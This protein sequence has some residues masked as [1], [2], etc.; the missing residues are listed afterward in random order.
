MALSDDEGSLVIYDNLRREV[1]ML[2]QAGEDLGIMGL[3]Q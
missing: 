3:M 1:H 2:G